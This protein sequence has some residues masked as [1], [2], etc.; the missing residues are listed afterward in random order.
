M[1]DWGLGSL[2]SHELSRK[3]GTPEYCAPEVIKGEYDYK[4]DLWSLGIL[5][6]VMLGG[7]FPFKGECVGETLLK[8]SKGVYHFRGP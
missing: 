5:L 1:I 6:Y 4:C 3:C 8:V 7:R 2:N